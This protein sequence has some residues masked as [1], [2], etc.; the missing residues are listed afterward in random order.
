MKKSILIFS[1]ICFSVALFAQKG[2]LGVGI[3]LGQPTGISAKLWNGRTTAFDAAAAWS[4][5]PDGG[6]MH[7]HADYLI[8][9]FELLQ[10]EEGMLPLYFGIGGKIILGPEVG[11]GVR[12]P[13]GI[14]YIFN[15]DLPLDA[16]LEIAPTLNLVP[17]TGFS[18]DGGIG[19]RYYF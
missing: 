6:A 7:L 17:S 14:S 4:I 13:L 1:F 3:I 16:F 18:I 2:N 19:V 5:N 11:F 12:V 15:D 10:V 9:N 8:H